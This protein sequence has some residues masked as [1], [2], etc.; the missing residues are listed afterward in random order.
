VRS[1]KE[2]HREALSSAE[3]RIAVSEINRS[4][5]QGT[6]TVRAEVCLSV[7]L[8]SFNNTGDGYHDFLTKSKRISSPGYANLWCWPM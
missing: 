4:L 2:N 6:R 7:C 1:T 8:M 3:R 5:V